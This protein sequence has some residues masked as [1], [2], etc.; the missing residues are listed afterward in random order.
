MKGKID[1]FDIA[2]GMNALRRGDTQREIK[3]FMRALSSYPERF[4]HNPCLSFEQHLCRIA[5]TANG[6]GNR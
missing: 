3:D 1:K 2:G 5:S 4:A 6:E